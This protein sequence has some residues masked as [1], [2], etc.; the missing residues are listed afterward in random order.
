MKVNP[1]KKYQKARS[2]KSKPNN[3]PKIDQ[4]VLNPRELIVLKLN[5]WGLYN[6]F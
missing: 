3:K 5:K 2:I 1:Q 4:I 6:K